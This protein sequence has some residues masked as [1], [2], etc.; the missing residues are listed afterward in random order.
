[1]HAAT[2]HHNHNS[3]TQLPHTKGAFYYQPCLQ[4]LKSM[5]M[6]LVEHQIKKHGK[7]DNRTETRGEAMRLTALF[8][9]A[10]GHLQELH[11][12]FRQHASWPVTRPAA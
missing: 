3:E 1:M 11:S 8:E 7:Q 2:S 6:L 5:V 9:S 10:E 12:H 4:H